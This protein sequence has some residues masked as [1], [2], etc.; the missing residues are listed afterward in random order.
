MLDF[1][2]SSHIPSPLLVP[3]HERYQ[4]IPVM[5]IHG[6]E[7]QTVP[8]E[9]RRQFPGAMPNLSKW[10]EMNQCK[11]DPV[12]T[13]RSG[14]SFMLTYENC[15]NGASVSHVSV[16]EGGHVTYKGVGTDID[17]SRMAWDFMSQ[18]SNT[19]ASAE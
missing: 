8:Y 14:E 3:P 1:F 12:E 11:G 6:T 9:A 13:W 19:G 4:P 7:D 5:Q 16:H 2:S 10:G 17:T 18:Y 15:A